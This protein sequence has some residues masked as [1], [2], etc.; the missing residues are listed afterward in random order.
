V[1]VPPPETAPEAAKTVLRE[2]RSIR[3]RGRDIGAGDWFWRAVETPSRV[4]IETIGTEIEMASRTEYRI[5]D[6]DPLSAAMETERTQTILRGAIETRVTLKARMTAT[7]AAFTVEAT[8]E[9]FEGEARVC[10]REWREM[11]P[12]D[13]A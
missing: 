5:R 6:D 11:V 12:R 2:G 13:L 1:T 10:R 4:R 9:A 3:E 8:L 7:A